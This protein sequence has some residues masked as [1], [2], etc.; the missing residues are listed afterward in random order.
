MEIINET[1]HAVGEI[2]GWEIF[3]IIA[4]CVLTIF[5]LWVAIKSFQ[6]QSWFCFSMSIVVIIVYIFCLIVCF[7]DVTNKV[8]YREYDVIFTEPIDINELSEK[9]EIKGND[10]R[11]WHL[12]DKH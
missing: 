8:E 3:R 11:I 4:F 6:D 9:Y 1:V 2:D 7:N 10:G 12:E 5:F